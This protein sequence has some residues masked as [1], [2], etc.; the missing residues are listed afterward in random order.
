MYTQTHT[1]THCVDFPGGASGKESACQ[2]R[3]SHKRPGFNLWAKN[4]WRR[5]CNPLLPGL[6]PGQR[7]LS[8]YSP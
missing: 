1:H 2:R 5:A 8:S 3:K 4:V 7:S 6:S